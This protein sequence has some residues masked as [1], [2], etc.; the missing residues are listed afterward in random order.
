M[1]ARP[2]SATRYGRAFASV[3]V[4]VWQ[5]RNGITKPNMRRRNDGRKRQGTSP[6]ENTKESA[7]FLGF[8]AARNLF[9][10]DYF[11]PI[12]QRVSR[13]YDARLENGR[14]PTHGYQGRD[15]TP[16]GRRNGYALTTM[17]LSSI[18]QRAR[19][20]ARLALSGNRF[21]NTTGIGWEIR[22]NGIRIGCQI[23]K[24]PSAHA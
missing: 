20:A 13:E 1:I 8:H 12:P 18:R 16:D 24:R 9:R 5:E 10:R 6:N 17:H 4:D 22:R 23:C 14:K 15:I 3:K 7:K 11:K 21:G 2:Y 19:G